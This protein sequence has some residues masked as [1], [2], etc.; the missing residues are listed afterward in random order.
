[1]ATVTKDE[2]D[3][4]IAKVKDEMLKI[5][6]GMIQQSNKEA[7]VNWRADF[8]FAA[9]KME[10]A[11][12]SAPRPK[13]GMT[14]K[15][16]F[17]SLRSYSGK[18]EEYD[19]WE[20]KMTAF[21]A[22]DPDFKE[23]LIKLKDVKDVPGKAEVEAIFKELDDEK[24]VEVDR[25][26]I[27]HQLFQV[28]CLNLQ[29]KALKSVK[30]LQEDKMKA[31]NGVVGWCKLAQ[32]TSAMTSQ[33]LQGLAGQ[34]YSPK[35]CKKY[36]EVSAA[37]EEWELNV[38]L[39]EKTE[40]NMTLSQQTRIYSVRQLVPEEL[41]KDI[42]RSSASLT[43]YE[44]VR[45]YITEQCTVRRDAK[46]SGSGPVQMDVNYV[47]KTLAAI[48]ENES[49]DERQCEESEHEEVEA[50][51]E[52]PEQ[53]AMEYLMSFVKGYKGQSKGYGKG[54]KGKDGGKGNKFEGTC[55]YCGTYGHRVSECWKKDADMKGGKGKGK[56]FGF[57]ANG[58][59]KGKGFGF[60]AN[61]KGFDNGKGYGKG[62]GK[63]FDNGK[64]KG[65]AYGFG[66]YEE[67]ATQ[68]AWTLSLYP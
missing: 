68:A 30:T 2:F 58:K 23:L 38:T 16:A 66:N 60:E 57:D 1:M 31:I 63:G 40:D 64:G 22:E 6:E 14:T 27:N 24:G 56:G 3:E 26:W 35:R 33:R 59:G 32:D 42:I 36:G 52:E 46:T 47:K 67:A 44:S 41:E 45:K 8:D 9:S 11:K 29:G 54:G 20:F 65:Y 37:I 17:S 61:G 10:S 12:Q 21:L 50:H 5:M 49:Y 55:H 15:R 7:Q 43:T 62:Y 39:F 48:M 25:D 18:Y 28:L 13:E 4:G 51:A 19:E 53:N 34:V